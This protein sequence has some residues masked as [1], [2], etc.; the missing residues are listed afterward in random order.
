MGLEEALRLLSEKEFFGD[1]EYQDKFQEEANDIGGRYHLAWKRRH[2]ENQKSLMS[3]AWW[4][5]L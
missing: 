5:E 3:R 4:S 1:D 2:Q